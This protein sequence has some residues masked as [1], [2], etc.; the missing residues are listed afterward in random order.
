MLLAG[1]GISN[2]TQST[3]VMSISVE[4]LRRAMEREFASW[5][6]ERT[7]MAELEAVD[8]APSALVRLALHQQSI[9]R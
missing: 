4:D 2:T 7:K 3:D 8:V 1:A 5:L 9:P 6:S